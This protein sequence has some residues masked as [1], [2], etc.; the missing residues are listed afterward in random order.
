MLSSK[1]SHRI[2]SRGYFWFLL[3]QCFINDEID[4]TD[5]KAHWLKSIVIGGA[6][7]YI[8]NPGHSFVTNLGPK[9]SLLMLDCRSVMIFLSSETSLNPFVPVRSARGTKSARRSLIDEFSNGWKP[10][11]LASSTSSS[12]WAFQ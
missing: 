2:G 11:R 4:G 6:G 1:E 12:S 7:A 3:F 9:T 5:S 10:F 8:P